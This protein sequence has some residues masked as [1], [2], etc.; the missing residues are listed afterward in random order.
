MEAIA[1]RRNGTV[2]LLTSPEELAEAISRAQEFERQNAELIALRAKRHEAALA[3]L[4]SLG[5]GGTEEAA[6]DVLPT[7][8]VSA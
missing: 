5:T 3:R 1:G 6:V 4:V 2:R 8:P 7:L